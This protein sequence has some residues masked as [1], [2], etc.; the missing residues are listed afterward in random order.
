[1][2]ESAG[3]DIIDLAT[4]NIQRTTQKR[5]YTKFIT[6]TETLLYS[7]PNLANL[8]FEHFV[9]LLWSAKESVYKFVQRHQSGLVFSP[10]KIII[11]QIIPPASTSGAGTVLLAETLG[12]GNQQ[13]YNMTVVFG[14]D[15]FYTSS[16]I[17]TGYIHTAANNHQSFD[18]VYWGVRQVAQ[19]D[20]AFQS[21]QVRKFILDK[22]AL[23]THKNNL[24]IVKNS[25]G[26]PILFSGAEEINQPLSLAHHG[27][28]VAYVF[29]E[30]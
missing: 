15:V 13:T 6:G 20:A 12:F 28:Y 23:V 16:I 3:N 22:L 24:N 8:P 14:A 7:N 21:L 5:F 29:P 30:K 11:T 19:S 25:G 1:M 4:I 2:I 27:H 17:T 18:R 10:S 26:C 9:W